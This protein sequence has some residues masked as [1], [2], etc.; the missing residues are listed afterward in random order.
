[1]TVSA[2]AGD[3]SLH[4]LEASLL[5]Y[6]QALCGQSCVFAPYTGEEERQ[7]P[8]TATTV[9]LPAHVHVPPTL[10]SDWYS[11]AVAHRAMHYEFGTFELDLYRKEPFFQVLRPAGTGQVDP[12]EPS[13]DFFFR[14]FSRPA[15]AIE[16]FM[17][18]EDLRVD[19]A[20]VHTL[21]GLRSI[22]RR[23]Q[24]DALGSRPDLAGMPPRSA[25]AEALVR[26]SLGASSVQAAASLRH[27]LALVTAA[28]APLRSPE[29]TVET[30]AEATIRAFSVLAK[31]PNLGDAAGDIEL[32]P[33]DGDPALREH[34]SF[35]LHS[36]E[37]RLEGDE[38]FD[39]RFA[40]VRYRDVPGPRYLGQS[41]SGMP[42][43]EAILR[44]TP[45]TETPTT[46]EVAN[47]ERS[48]DAE[49]GL[50]D[51]T[52]DSQPAPP[53]EPLPHDHGPDLDSH[54]HPTEGPVHAVARGEF[55]YPEWDG[56]TSTYLPDWCLVR[57]SRPESGRGDHVYRE[58]LRRHRHLLS[59]LTR[60]LERMADTGL[61]RVTRMPYG[62][63]LDFDACIE[64]T[65][66]MRLG[67]AASEQIYTATVRDNRD[68]VVAFA[69]DLSS[70]TAE[71]LPDD[72]DRPGDTRRILDVE[73][74]AVVLLMTALE[75]VGDAYGIYG[76]SGTGRRDVQVKVVKDIDEH[77]SPALLRRFDGMKPHHTTRMGPVIRHLAQRLHKHEAATK[78]LMIISDGRPFDIDY[79]QQYGEGAE[80]DYALAD[81]AQALSDARRLG[82]RPHLITVDAAGDDYLRSV[83]DG[84]DY[85]VIADARDL[86][87]SLASLYLSVLRDAPSM[88]SGAL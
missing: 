13:L 7:H 32:I 18:L 54:H 27:P 56:V 19:S 47:L 51:V 63:D 44:M 86:P 66:D 71:R 40:P 85:Q 10:G 82:V 21:P 22:Y 12:G 1:M 5:L 84:Q 62:D 75:R 28:A 6:Y 70:S 43:R 30:T 59:A 39:L 80:L 2:V 58:A 9:R 37:L 8:D 41:T 87:D 88:K 76:F 79:G 33:L 50:V 68:V 17:T 24:E 67:V 57:E 53:P 34:S 38:V 77:R 35:N 14:S 16:V 55:V 69:L 23:A 4:G 72:P 25:V 83:C 78:L 49:A 3:A 20:A 46:A 60:N 74:E 73:R 81:T 42:M 11:V 48:Q 31:L 52:D 29:A 36:Q 26:C 61:R 65:V 45:E 64:A 15:L